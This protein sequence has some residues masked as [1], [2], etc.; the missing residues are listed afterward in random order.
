MNDRIDRRG[1]L[2]AAGAVL[3]VGTWPIGLHAMPSG[4]P[5]GQTVA[6]GTWSSDWSID[7]MWS[8]LPR[9]TARVG[10]GRRI[11]A[12]VVD[13]AAVDRQLCA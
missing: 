1:F 5:D 10:L 6:V 7:D 4:V 9:P 12:C 11:G 3:T 2:G 8:L 13:V